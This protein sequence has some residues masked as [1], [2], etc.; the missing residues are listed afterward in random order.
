M[1]HQFVRCAVVV[2]TLAASLGSVTP[3]HA[4]ESRDASAMQDVL[5]ILKREGMIDEAGEQKILA[6]HAVEQESSLPRFLDGLEITGDL[7]LRYEPQFFDGDALGNEADNR[8]RFRYRARFGVTKKINDRVKVGFRLASGASDLRSTN[9]SFGEGADDEFTPD[10][11]FFDRAFVELVLQDDR[12]M[13]TKLIAG[14]VANPFVGKVGPD[15]V[16]FDNDI[17]ME[18]AHLTT[19]FN[20]GENTKIHATLGSFV[21][22]EVA[23]EGDP[24]LYGGQLGFETK[25]GA[26]S[27]GIR[28]STY[29]YRSLDSNRGLAPARIPA[30]QSR[31]FASGN[32]SSAFDDGKVRMGETF[33]YAQFGMS[34]AFPLLVYATA[35]KNFTADSQIINGIDVDEEDM[36]Y[37][38]GFELG[39]AS[40]FVKLGIGYFRVEAN[41]VIAQ[42]TDSDLFD[43]FTN[44]QGFVL[45]ASRKMGQNTEF[46]LTAFDSDDIED[47]GRAGGP[48]APSL[49]NADRQRVQADVI[50]SY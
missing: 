47:E 39:S 31:A 38:F 30:F 50:F 9:T 42:F 10:G 4:Q 26:L 16:V 25:S 28:A 34:E 22:D 12:R 44:R 49:A 1:F 2:G 14:K 46:R 19:S 24:S 3:A 45:Y 18:G 7:R 35:V 29:Q 36:A 40:R 17:N 48:F 23:A 27:L 20:L 8:Y 11:I 15:F 41:S 6:K 43:G 37:G 5:A 21:I 13:Q 32:L 33:A